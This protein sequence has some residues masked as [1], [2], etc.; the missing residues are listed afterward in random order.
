MVIQYIIYNKKA[1]EYIYEYIRKNF[2]SNIKHSKNAIDNKMTSAC[3]NYGIKIFT[4]KDYFLFHNQ[5]QGSTWLN[6]CVLHKDGD[7]ECM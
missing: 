2:T 7:Y 5:S 1:F 6:K 3:K 4:T